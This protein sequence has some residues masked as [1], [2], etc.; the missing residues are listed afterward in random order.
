VG[1]APGTLKFLRGGARIRPWDSPESL[2]VEDG[3]LIAA[4]AALPS[5]GRCDEG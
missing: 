2:G 3:E 1:A 4:A 5:I